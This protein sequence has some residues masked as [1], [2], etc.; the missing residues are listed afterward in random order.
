MV[1]LDRLS[2]HDLLVQIAT[3]VGVVEELE[4]RVGASELAIV[5]LQTESRVAT[6]IGSMVAAVVG[7]FVRP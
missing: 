2:D 1:Q 3:K 5:R 4:R 7:I 6:A